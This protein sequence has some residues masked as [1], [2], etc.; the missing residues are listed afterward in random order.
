MTDSE[1][2]RADDPQAEVDVLFDLV[3]RRY[4]DRLTGGELEGVRQAIVGIVEGARALRAVR[5]GSADE[6]FQ[7]FVPFRADP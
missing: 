5:L 2:A 7:P 6:P 3:R 1:R 4:G